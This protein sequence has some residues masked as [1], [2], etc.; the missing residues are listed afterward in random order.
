M[1]SKMRQQIAVKR[2]RLGKWV[3]AGS[4]KVVMVE[5]RRSAIRRIIFR[6]TQQQFFFPKALQQ[7]GPA[8]CGNLQHCGVQELSK[9]AFTLARA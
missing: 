5:V 8:H 4:A 9:D 1:K 2:N 6:A 3:E 7:P